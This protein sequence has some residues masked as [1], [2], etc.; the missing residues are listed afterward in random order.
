M[1]GQRL[2]SPLPGRLREARLRLDTVAARLESASYERVLA[3][4]FT[5]VTTPK[6]TAVTAAAKVA[7]GT[8]LTLHFADGIVAVRAEK[9]TAQLDFG[10]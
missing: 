2:A 10:L 7:P 9:P 3:R 8:P 4:G 6:G 1:L 5:L